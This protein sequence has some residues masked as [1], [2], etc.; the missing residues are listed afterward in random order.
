MRVTERQLRRIIREEVSRL[1]EK[2]GESAL[3]KAFFAGPSASV[4]TGAIAKR[5]DDVAAVLG[6]TEEEVK[7]AVKRHG[8]S[9]EIALADAKGGTPVAYEDAVH[10]VVNQKEDYRGQGLYTATSATRWR[11]APYRYGRRRR[12]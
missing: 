2:V 3:E 9:I 4:A 10:I 6:V 8:D 7:Q 1:N 12:Y 5:I 11:D